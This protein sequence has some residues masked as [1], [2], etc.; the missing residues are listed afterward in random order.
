M[1]AQEKN[2]LLKL[3][4]ILQPNYELFHIFFTNDDYVKTSGANK[5]TTMDDITSK[6]NQY[7]D[8]NTLFQS[9]KRWR[10]SLYSLKTK[11]KNKASCMHA[12]MHLSIF[13]METEKW[14]YVF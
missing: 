6:K 13:V 11:T 12:C 2:T 10:R 8:V 14:Q 3:E 5:R 1:D 7:L 4:L 9:S